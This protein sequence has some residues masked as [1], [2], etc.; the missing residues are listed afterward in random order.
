[1]ARRLKLPNLAPLKEFDY[2]LVQAPLDGLLINVNRDLQRRTAQAE[3]LD[4]RTA[5]RCLTLLDV[6]VRFSVNSF[7]AIRYVIAETPED[8]NR[9]PNYALVLAPVN[10]Q[11]LDLLFSLIYMLDDFE[12]R[13]LRYQRAGWRE[14]NEE[15]HKFKT[16]YSSAP[17]WKAYFTGGERVITYYADLLGIAAAERKRPS[18]IPYWK[19]P[20]EL[21]DERTRS[22]P[23][24]RWL[25]K[26][27][28]GDTS[29]QAHLS[30]GGLLSV[31]P[32][33]VAELVGG[34]TL[35]IVEERMLVQYKFLHF[36]RMALT[37]LAIAT[38]ID[39][40]CKLGNHEQAGYVWKMFVEHVP[41]GRDMY[42]AR[43]EKLTE[44]KLEI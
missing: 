23:F 41:E 30:F 6:M 9:K 27:L 24:L 12:E 7:R 8:H 20:F 14:M 29:A 15:Y 28:Y 40:H 34:Q 11:L 32:M 1:M 4:N 36:S 33:L 35:E 38:E 42:E 43:Y 37:V 3:R 44:S 2:A 18:L 5:S 19:H 10:R 26:W 31:A 21:K 25:D 17:E 22:R 13:S 39:S 16:T